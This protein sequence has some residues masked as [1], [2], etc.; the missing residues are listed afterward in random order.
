MRDYYPIFALLALVIIQISCSRDQLIES[1]NEC[2]DEVTYAGIIKPIIDE[3]CAY[4]GCHDG[5]AGIGPGNYTRYDEALLRDLTN[6]SFRN[7]VFELKDNPIQ[8][9]PPNKTAF[10]ESLKDDLTNEELDLIECWLEGG[11]PEN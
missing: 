3:S 1:T 11:F 4:T 10:E 2:I 6:G 7:R 9:M 5:G 8:G